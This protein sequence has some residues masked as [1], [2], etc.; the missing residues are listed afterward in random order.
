MNINKISSLQTNTTIDFEHATIYIVVLNNKAYGRSYLVGM[1][2]RDGLVP[3]ALAI[4]TGILVHVLTIPNS[5]EREP[6]D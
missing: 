4:A 6:Y 5:Q 2:L 1:T 3:T